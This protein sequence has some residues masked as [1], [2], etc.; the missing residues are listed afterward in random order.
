M[1]MLL[2]FALIGVLAGFPLVT[3]SAQDTPAF[4]VASV[5]VST[6]APPGGGYTYKV[7]P[8][9]ITITRSSMGYCIRVAYDLMQRPSELVG[10][11]WIDPPTDLLVDIVAKTA[12]PTPPDQVKLMLQRL[13]AERFNL[14]VHRELRDVPVY[15]LR[16]L[17]ERT[18]LQPST[19][20][21]EPKSKTIG[22]HKSLYE[23]VS[24]DQLAR[25][26]GPPWLSRRVV[27]KTELTG[28]YDFT[29]DLA[30][31]LI[32]PATGTPIT[33]AQGRVDEETAMARAFRDQLGL[34]LKPARAPVPVLVVD[35][36]DKDTTGN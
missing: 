10:P 25:A 15:E 32:D 23:H 5:K 4:E 27:D 3:I 18:I 20:D 35:R 24:M 28:S 21:G 34:A 11:A 16:R 6:G 17:N 13:L 36:V 19:S 33:D 9:G 22:P 1:K 7:T 30:P 12:V 29:L 2:P 8:R 14:K 26:L 31:Y